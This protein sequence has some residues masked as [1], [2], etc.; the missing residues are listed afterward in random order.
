MGLLKEERQQR[1]FQTALY[2]EFQARLAWSLETVSTNTSE[3]VLPSSEKCKHMHISDRRVTL[4]FSLCRGG[5]GGLFDFIYQYSCCLILIPCMACRSL[6]C[7]HCIPVHSLLF[8]LSHYT[9]YT[10]GPTYFHPL[11]PIKESIQRIEKIRDIK[12]HRKASLFPAI[13]FSLIPT[14]D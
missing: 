10:H 6:S 8:L 2:A 7:C 13:Y 4:Y 1:R 11:N 12:G 9:E 14:L 5:G 3:I